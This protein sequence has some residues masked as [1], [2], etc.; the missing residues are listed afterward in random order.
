[1]AHRAA[2]VAKF[3]VP[4][5]VIFFVGRVILNN[6]EQVRTAD[7]DVRPGYLALSFVLSCAWFVFRP[8]GW[9]IILNGFGRTRCHSRMHFAKRAS[10]S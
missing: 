4:L 5:I 3:V 8:F 10:L 7:W 9:N 2:R 1:M 6:W